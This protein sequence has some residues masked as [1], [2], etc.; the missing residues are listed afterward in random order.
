VRIGLEVGRDHRRPE[1]YRTLALL[2]LPE[3]QGL[4]PAIRRIETALPPLMEA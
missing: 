1:T 2:G 3:A 4:G